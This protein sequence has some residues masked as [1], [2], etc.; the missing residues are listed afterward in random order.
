MANVVPAPAPVTIPVE[1][2]DGVFTVRTIRMTV[3]P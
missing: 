2:S 1:G 3:T